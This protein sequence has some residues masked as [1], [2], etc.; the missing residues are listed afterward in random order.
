MTH[1]PLCPS[2]DGSNDIYC[3]CELI[4]KVREDERDCDK[5]GEVIRYRCPHYQQG[6]QDML[7]KCIAVVEACGD[8]KGYVYSDT[9]TGVVWALDALRA[10]QEGQT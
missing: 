9:M 1:D 6:R 10:L 7:A 4:A 5:H 2:A 8:D 3:E